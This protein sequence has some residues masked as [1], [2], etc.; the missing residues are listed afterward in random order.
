MLNA[1]FADMEKGLAA[2][3]AG[4]FETAFA[5][6]KI[7]AAS[8]NAEAQ[9]LLSNMYFDGIGTTFNSEEGMRWLR[10]AAE[11]DHHDAQFALGMLYSNGR[12]VEKNDVEA[13][14]WSLKSA[15]NGNLLG[16]FS[17]GTFYMQGAGTDV[18]PELGVDWHLRAAEK[19]LSESQ[20]ALSIIYRTGIGA[21]KDL[22]KSFDY[23]KAAAASGHPV[24]VQKINELGITV[25]MDMSVPSNAILERAEFA[26]YSD[27]MESAYTAY[28]EAADM[29]NPIAQYQVGFFH[30]IGQGGAEQSFDEAHKWF[31]TAAEKGDVLAIHNLGVMNMRGH[32]R[33]IDMVKAAAWFLIADILDKGSEAEL[34]RVLVPKLTPEQISEAEDEANKWFD[35]NL[36]KD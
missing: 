13:F 26:S 21:E 6:Y 16:Y 23:L 36:R 31:T 35:A 33:D 32:G 30:L 5:E 24:A 2:A 10:A 15:E 28:K 17:V 25:N 11:Q 19:G 34:L 14:N 20:N 1:A 12:Y 18:N 29:E 8:G 22:R 27:D 3:Q 4:D 9:F 7:D